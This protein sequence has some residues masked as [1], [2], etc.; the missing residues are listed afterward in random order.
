MKNEKDSDGHSYF[1]ENQ[2]TRGNKK[3]PITHDNVIYE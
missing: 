2:G 1:V 3:D